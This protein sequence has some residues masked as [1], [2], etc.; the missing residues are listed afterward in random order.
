[1]EPRLRLW[2]RWRSSWMSEKQWGF[3]STCYFGSAGYWLRSGRQVMGCSW[4]CV[5][6][7]RVNGPTL[8][9]GA[10]HRRWWG[11]FPWVTFLLFSAAVGL[12]IMFLQ[13][14]LPVSG[15]ISSIVS[16]YLLSCVNADWCFS[17][18]LGLFSV[19]QPS[20][21]SFHWIKDLKMMFYSEQQCLLPSV[22]RDFC[23]ASFFRLSFRLNRLLLACLN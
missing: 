9:P 17:H 12:K 16:L 21:I 5:R 19:W 11:K 6:R 8:I 14:S 18:N 23:S 7:C 15:A 22:C 13:I 1:M 10:A 4:I 20:F 3:W 2:A